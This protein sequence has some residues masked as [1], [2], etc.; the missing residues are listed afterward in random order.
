MARPEHD[1]KFFA[2]RVASDIVFRHCLSLLARCRRWDVVALDISFQE[3]FTVAKDIVLCLCIETW[4]LV[5]RGA[6]HCGS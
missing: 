5:A 4:L 3:F 6:C 2:Y 1:V